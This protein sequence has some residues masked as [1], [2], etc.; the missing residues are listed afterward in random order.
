MIGVAARVMPDFPSATFGR[1]PVVTAREPGQA[2]IPMPPTSDRGWGKTWMPVAAGHD[3]RGGTGGD[4]STQ[5]ATDAHIAAMTC[6]QIAIIPRNR[7]IEASAA[8]SSTTA[9]NMMSS[10]NEQRT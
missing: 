7:V 5:D 10:M 4:R 1:R 8:A 2:R 6:D 9:R 3:E